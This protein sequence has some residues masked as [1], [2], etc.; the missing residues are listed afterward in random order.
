MSSSSPSPN[1]NSGQAL[2]HLKVRLRSLQLLLR[3]ILNVFASRV[4]RRARQ[5]NKGNVHVTGAPC[6][7]VEV[8]GQR[9]G[10]RCTS[11]V[12]W[13]CRLWRVRVKKYVS[14]FFIMPLEINS[15]REAH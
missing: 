12:L 9:A 14:A 7:L 13:R 11:E 15:L 4:A 3:N 8:G 5:R 10:S 6:Q 1:S 2:N